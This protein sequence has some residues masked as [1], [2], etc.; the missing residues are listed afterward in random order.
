MSR[1]IV[2]TGGGTGGHV[3][4]CQLRK[5]ARCMILFSLGMVEGKAEESIVPKEWSGFGPR[6]KC[7][8]FDNGLMILVLMTLVA[9]ASRTHCI[10]LRFKPDAIVA[11]GVCVG[12]IIFAAGIM[13]KI[14]LLKSRLSYE[15][16]AGWTMNKVAIRFADKVADFFPGTK[17]VVK[18][19][20]RWIP[21]EDVLLLKVGI[22]VNHDVLLGKK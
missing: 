12:S 7:Y 8:S 13:N 1:K 6:R 10:L 5:F 9:A 15:A 16:N 3:T 19:N 18:R 4:Q 2:F 21:Y 11:T 17:G 20:V 22:R 14:G